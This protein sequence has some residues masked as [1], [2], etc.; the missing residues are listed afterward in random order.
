MAVVYTKEPRTSPPGRASRGKPMAG[1]PVRVRLAC[2]RC[3]AHKL[4]CPKQAGSPVC[5]RCARAGAA[6][7]FSPPGGKAPSAPPRNEAGAPVSPAAA[8]VVSQHTE[9]P[10]PALLGNDEVDYMDQFLDATGLTWP[11]MY[12]E[13]EIDPGFGVISPDAEAAPGPGQ[14]CPLINPADTAPYQRAEAPP[15]P[16]APA[17]SSPSSPTL[18]DNND[19]GAAAAAEQPGPPPST[20][21]HRLSGVLQDL[22]SVLRELPA[23]GELLPHVRYGDAASFQQKLLALAQQQQRDYSET[24]ERLFRSSQALVELYPSAVAEALGGGGGLGDDD[25]N[26]KNG[27]SSSSKRPRGARQACE[28]PDCAH[29]LPTPRDLAGLRDLLLPRRHESDPGP[30]ADAVD[31]ALASLLVACH[32]RFLDVLDGLFAC[33]VACF[34][35]TAASPGGLAEPDFDLPEVRVGS[36]VPPRGSRVLVQA[37]LLRQVLRGLGKGARRLAAA[38]EEGGTRA[39]GE[40]GDRSVAAREVRALR[41]QCEVLREKHAAREERCQDVAAALVRF[42]MMK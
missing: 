37:F 26:D 31:A 23:E 25:S 5:T 27:S 40:D 33:A 35:A 6:C 39:G 10:P 29:E 24:L 2:D 1:H 32:L 36:F 9:T 17:D 4:R 30:S 34:T 18:D 8:P 28:I 38:L 3:H 7:V 14:D 20:T 11:M 13:M 41:L 22:D 15:R 16:S 12:Q 21:T 19:D 42:E